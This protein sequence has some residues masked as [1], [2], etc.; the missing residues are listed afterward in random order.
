MTIGRSYRR[1]M[2]LQ[3]TVLF[4]PPGGG[5]PPEPVE[6]EVVAAAGSTAGQLASALAT[7]DPWGRHHATSISVSGAF[8]ASAAVVGTHPLVDG[9][10]LTLAIQPAASSSPGPAAPRSPVTLSVTHGPDAGRSIELVPGV[11]TVGRGS[12]AAVVIDDPRISRVHAVISVDADSISVADAG[13]TNGTELDGVRVGADPHP[14][15]LG[16]GGEGVDD[17]DDPGRHNLQSGLLAHLAHRGF[18]HGLANRLRPARQAPLPHPRRLA[19]PDQQNLVPAPDDDPNPDPGTVGIF[20][21]GTVRRA[22]GHER[23][24]ID[25]LTRG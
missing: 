23:L 16:I 3:L 1:R 8:V 10:A 22:G 15:A 6:V 21:A 12:E 24:P 18:E 7:L 17:S 11:H 13:S 25:G 19:P 9:A 5:P 14:A 2:R 4:C 20:A